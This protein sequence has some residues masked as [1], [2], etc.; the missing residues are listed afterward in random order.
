MYFFGGSIALL[1]SILGWESKLISR[2]LSNQGYP[3]NERE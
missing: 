1:G 3:E 2:V